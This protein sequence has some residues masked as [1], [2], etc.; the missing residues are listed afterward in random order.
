MRCF[1][2]WM[3]IC[4]ANS[5]WAQNS[6]GELSP[7]IGD[8]EIVVRNQS[9][10]SQIRS[11]D[12]FEIPV[13]VPLNGDFLQSESISE[14]LGR[15][16][17]INSPEPILFERPAMRGMPERKFTSKIHL[18]IKVYSSVP[19]RIAEHLA[20]EPWTTNEQLE[21]RLPQDCIPLIFPELILDPGE[22][23]TLRLQDDTIHVSLK[24]AAVY[25]DA[26]DSKHD[27][28]SLTSAFYRTEATPEDVLQTT[29]ISD[30]MSGISKTVMVDADPDSITS[31][32]SNDSVILL[33]ITPEVIREPVPTLGIFF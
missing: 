14:S 3:L 15:G 7:L 9:A 27:V 23:H 5:A 33:Q 20:N 21:Q 28:I 6:S 11:G 1:V 19:R 29:Q 4:I 32:L 2:A 22:V 13:H 18:N 8:P 24:A 30:V 25:N 31:L 26:A 12:P 16:A 17:W 10:V